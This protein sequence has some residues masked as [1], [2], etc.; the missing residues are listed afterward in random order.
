MLYITSFPVLPCMASVFDHLQYANTESESL[1]DL[2][3][4]SGR[5][6]VDRRRALPDAVTH[7]HILCCSS[8]PNNELY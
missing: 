5:K 3:M 7:K 8:L 6:R 4:M 2:I 1:R